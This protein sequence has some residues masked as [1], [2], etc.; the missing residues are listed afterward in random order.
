MIS[1]ESG[2]LIFTLIEGEFVQTNCYVEVLIDD[3]VFPSYSSSKIKSKQHEFNESK[4]RAQKK[5]RNL[6]DL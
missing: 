6:S 4:S 2:L 1:T 5:H 3:L